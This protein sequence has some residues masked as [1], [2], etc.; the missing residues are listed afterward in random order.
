LPT[1]HLSFSILWI[2]RI[3]YSISLPNFLYHSRLEIIR[4]QWT[5]V[6][7]LPCNLLSWFLLNI[8]SHPDLYSCYGANDQLPAH[9]SRWP[10]SVHGK[11]TSGANTTC[12][13]AADTAATAAATANSTANAASTASTTNTATLSASYFSE[14]YTFECARQNWRTSGLSGLWTANNDENHSRSREYK[15][16][17]SHPIQ[18]DVISLAF[19]FLGKPW[20]GQTRIRT[21][22]NCDS[23]HGQ[24]LFASLPDS[25]A[26]FHTLWTL[27]RTWNT[28]VGLVV[29]YL[30]RHIKV[31]RWMYINTTSELWCDYSRDCW[32]R[33][34]FVN[35]LYLIK[36]IYYIE[37]VFCNDSGFVICAWVT[38][39]YLLLYSMMLHQIS[40]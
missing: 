27:L 39:R 13:N 24:A 10:R 33:V 30:P 1:W 17:S 23:V 34:I 26:L 32:G 6:R 7:R 8:H 31:G 5:N 37:W 21:N 28:G 12:N 36:F 16:V 2:L 20:R 38:A 22:V 11:G 35:W 18:R 9:A 15:P 19:S 29:C 4:P 14:C 25:Y 40:G 3:Y